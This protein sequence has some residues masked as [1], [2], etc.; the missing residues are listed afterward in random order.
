M[1]HAG[2]SELPSH[3]AGLRED[4]RVVRVD[5]PELL[6]GRGFGCAVDRLQ[7]RIGA[8]A[9]FHRRGA[10][11]ATVQDVRAATQL[12]GA[13]DLDVVHCV[14]HRPGDGNQA[15]ALEKWTHQF[16]SATPISPTNVSESRR[17]PRGPVVG[18]AELPD[19]PV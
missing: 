4:A 9:W 15:T 16:G 19:V 12:A 7:R 13:A 5:D 1:R 8:A 18:P 10:L 3:D 6:R 14:V 11:P 2:I 17:H